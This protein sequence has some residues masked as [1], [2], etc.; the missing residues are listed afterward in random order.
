L[1]NGILFIIY[2]GVAVEIWKEGIFGIG[3]LVVGLML[4][5]GL[6]SKKDICICVRGWGEMGRIGVSTL[7]FRVCVWEDFK[8]REKCEGW[9]K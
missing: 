3:C 1:K 8:R 7:W 2:L 4:S 5:L 9:R 6:V